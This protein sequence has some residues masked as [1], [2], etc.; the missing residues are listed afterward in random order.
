MKT[1]VSNR[2]EPRVEAPYMRNEVTVA[3]WGEKDYL[4][5]LWRHPYDQSI[6]M[7]HRFA[8]AIAVMEMGIS[9]YSLIATAV[10]LTV[11]EVKRVDMAKDLSIRQL[12][13]VGI[14]AG[15]SFE[16]QNFVCCPKCQVAVGFAPC[17]A[18]RTL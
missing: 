2:I 1:T 15:E 10:G 18:C 6:E 12:A 14:P 16:L 13:V 11:E 9:E 17:F 3:S 7:P 8:A 5:K 4:R